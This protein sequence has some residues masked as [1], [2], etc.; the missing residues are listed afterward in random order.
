MP[1]VRRS[2]PTCPISWVRQRKNFAR[3]LRMLDS[4]FARA[5]D[6]DDASFLIVTAGFL[7]NRRY[8][9]RDG[10]GFSEGSLAIAQAD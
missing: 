8:S 4:M 5:W 10:R 3:R 1:T 2:R 6:P 9:E 7:L